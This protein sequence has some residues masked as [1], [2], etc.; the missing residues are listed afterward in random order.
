MLSSIAAPLTQTQ[1]P[2]GTPRSQVGR[3]S[4]LPSLVDGSGHDAPDSEKNRTVS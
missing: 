1:D 4:S 2:S 3:T